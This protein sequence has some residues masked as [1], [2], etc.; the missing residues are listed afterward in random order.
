M[1]IAA[2]TPIRPPDTVPKLSSVSSHSRH[3]EL[4][5]RRIAA[6]EAPDATLSGEAEEEEEADATSSG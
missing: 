6:V 1:S 2:S 4:G 5:L 3:S